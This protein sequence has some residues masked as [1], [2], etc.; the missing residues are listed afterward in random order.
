MSVFVCERERE[1]ECDWP[2][3]CVACVFMCVRERE[4]DGQIEREIETD[5]DTET[6]LSRVLVWLYYMRFIVLY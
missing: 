4:R 6:T 3:R 1:R 5:R 2:S